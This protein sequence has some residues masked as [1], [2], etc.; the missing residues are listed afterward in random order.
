VIFNCTQEKVLRFL[1]PLIIERRHVDELLGV[2]GPILAT[3]SPVAASK[4]VKA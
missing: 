3:I 2:L 1:P 4:G